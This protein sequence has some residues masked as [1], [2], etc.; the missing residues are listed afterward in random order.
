MRSAKAG[1]V[2]LTL[3]VYA[4]FLE[5]ALHFVITRECAPVRRRDADLNG[6][7]EACFLNDIVPGGVFGQLIRQMVDLLADVV[8]G[9]GPGSGSRD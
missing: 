8:G 2:H 5:G 6:S 1:C 4:P 7:A 9:S 3:N